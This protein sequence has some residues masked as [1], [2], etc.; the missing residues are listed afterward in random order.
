MP[1]YQMPKR[2]APSPPGTDWCRLG[3]MSTCTIWGSYTG[4]YEDRYLDLCISIST[5]Q[6]LFSIELIAPIGVPVQRPIN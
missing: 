3:H 1:V 2:I 6:S 5:K 4:L